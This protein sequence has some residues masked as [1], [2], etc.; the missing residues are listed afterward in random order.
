MT[1]KNFL[2]N[3]VKESG[4]NKLYNL[5]EPK[6]INTVRDIIKKYSLGTHFLTVKQL[7]EIAKEVLES[8]VNNTI[9]IISPYHLSMAAH[10]LWNKEIMMSKNRYFFE[11]Y[12]GLINSKPR[13][14][15]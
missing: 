3:I 15:R 6:I 7:D 8:F 10:C 2:D 12:I 4:A 5:P 14:R 13:I 1:F 9:D 11:Y